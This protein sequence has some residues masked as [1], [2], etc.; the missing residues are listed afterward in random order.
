MSWTPSAFAKRRIVER[1]HV[2]TPLFEGW[3][4]W[5]RNVDELCEVGLRKT[6]RF[7][8]LPQFHTEQD[9]IR[10]RVS[11]RR[12]AARFFGA[13]FFFVEWSRVHCLIA[14]IPQELPGSHWNC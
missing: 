1:A 13:A 2:S 4:A 10:S 5:L 3:Q 11:F 8:C 9:G 6:R 7:A 14:S 12:T